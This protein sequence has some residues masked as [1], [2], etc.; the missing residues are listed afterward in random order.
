MMMM[1]MIVL[2]Q[3]S[4]AKWLNETSSCCRKCWSNV[5][6]LN[7]NSSL[8]ARQW[9]HKSVRMSYVW[10]FCG[11]SS[12]GPMTI[13]KLLEDILL[14]SHR[15]ASLCRNLIRYLR[16]THTNLRTRFIIVTYFVTIFLSFY[17]VLHYTILP[18]L[19]D[20]LHGFYDHFHT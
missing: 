3:V 15:S 1:M 19:L 20:W 10:S 18:R 4:G 8:W 2:F 11:H 14:T 9:E 13:A 6:K 16:N 12:V 17:Q 5:C 7:A